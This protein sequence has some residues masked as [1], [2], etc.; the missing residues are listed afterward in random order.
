MAGRWA[1]YGSELSGCCTRLEFRVFS[2]C[3]SPWVG[4]HAGLSCETLLKG[5]R[6]KS[7]RPDP[8][9]QRAEHVVEGRVK[10][11]AV[12]RGPPSNSSDILTGP[13]M[14]EIPLHDQ[15]MGQEGERGGVLDRALSLSAARL[16]SGSF[17]EA[18]GS[19]GPASKAVVGIFETEGLFGFPEGDLE[20]PATGIESQDF[21]D[22]STGIGTEV[23]TH[24][25][26][27]VGIAGQDQAD[28][29]TGRDGVPE[30]RL[31]FEL[32]GDA[33]SVK[34]Q[35]ETLPSS[36]A[37]RQGSRGWQPRAALARSAHPCVRLHRAV[38][39]GVKIHGPHEP[40]PIAEATKQ[41]VAGVFGIAEHAERA[42]L[43]QPSQQLSQ[44]LYGELGPFAIVLGRARSLRTVQTKQH[45]NRLASVRIP[46]QRQP[47]REH[48]PVVTEG[49]TELAAAS[50]PPTIGGAERIVKHPSAI[51][52]RTRPLTQRVID[53]DRDLGW[54]EA[55]Q[56]PKHH[57]GQVVHRPPSHRQK[58]IHRR[59]VSTAEKT[60]RSLDHPT[61]RV[62]PGTENPAHDQTR[63]MP[64]AGP[65]ETLA[66]ACEEILQALWYIRCAHASSSDAD[67]FLTVASVVRACSFSGVCRDSP[68]KRET[69]D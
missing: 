49:K 54:Q 27:I 46:R 9:L 23:G 7:C 29:T 55:K 16:R 52:V 59:K 26:V 5:S 62:F 66:E 24:L 67:G 36:R 37:L 10:L 6:K 42:I 11:L 4:L 43:R 38:E 19:G 60:P 57:L 68:K 33:P 14:V 17:G 63:K 50:R 45:G 31:G 28:R 13:T 69:R 41:R 21:R 1:A 12:P 56:A 58:P 48:H 35:H 25:P 8:A 22:T 39:S 61:D 3:E 65:S 34:A 53:H 20:F 2:G 32:K 64:K 47:D 44:E 40:H 30:A 51:K 18:S 15:G